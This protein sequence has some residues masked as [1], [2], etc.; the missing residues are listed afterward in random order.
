MRVALPPTR[1][2]TAVMS[3][4]QMFTVRITFNADSADTAE[5]L[6]TAFRSN[7]P[8]LAPGRVSVQA[9]GRYV[10]VEFDRLSDDPTIGPSSVGQATPGAE[11]VAALEG[12]SHEHSVAIPLLRALLTVI[13]M[14]E[15]A[16]LAPRRELRIDVVPANPLPQDSLSTHRSESVHPARTRFG[17]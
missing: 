7:G 12:F 6:S 5:R 17:G 16:G 15:M 8:F 2:H 13:A 4:P 14:R 9:E 3:A 1:L 10:T 11:I